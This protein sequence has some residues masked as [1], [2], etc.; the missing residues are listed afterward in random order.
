MEK[1]SEE[2]EE[3]WTEE[4]TMGAEEEVEAKGLCRIEEEADTMYIVELINWTLCI[5]H[6][7]LH[8]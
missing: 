4:G 8:V 5:D 7:Y 1:L 3:E 2:E 6:I